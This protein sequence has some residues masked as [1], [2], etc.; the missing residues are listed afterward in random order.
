MK[1][2]A[3]AGGL[4]LLGAFGLLFGRAFAFVL[5]AF[6]L[7]R[8]RCS[9]GGAMIRRIESRAFK[10]DPHG[11]DDLLERLLVTFGAAGQRFLVEVL[12]AVELHTAIFTAIRVNGHT[13]LF[14]CKLAERIIAH[15]AT[16][17]KPVY[18]SREKYLLLKAGKRL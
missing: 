8:A 15:L 14:P 9:G 17:D 11:G 1:P 2:P 13:Y 5:L 18:E 6:S 3:F 4:I 7:G 10:D 16:S 12:M